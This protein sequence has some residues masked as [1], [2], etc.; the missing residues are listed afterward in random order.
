MEL[1]KSVEQSILNYNL[2]DLQNFLKNRP[3]TNKNP[4]LWMA[5]S[6]LVFI[7]PFI[8]SILGFGLLFNLFL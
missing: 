7:S 2:T 8:L 5:I 1:Q 4:Y 6:L 3:S